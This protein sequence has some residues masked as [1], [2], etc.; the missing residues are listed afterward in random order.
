MV[1][2]Q[3]RFTPGPVD[4][5]DETNAR[6]TYTVSDGNG[7]AV[8]GDISVSV[9]PRIVAQ[10]PYARDDSTFTTVDSPVTI[11]VLR[12]D[13]DPSG[14]RPTLVGI[15]G[16]P[17]GGRAVVTA[18]SQVRYDPPAGRAGAFRCSYEVRNSQGLRAN[19]SIIVSVR[20]PLVTQRGAGHD[21]RFD[22]RR[23]RRRSS[24]ST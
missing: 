17:S 20:E 19:A 6:F 13:G 10:P 15:P 7:H 22:D 8:T 9:L 12:N 4:D 16:C 14:D 5:R 24:R 11:D 3:V 2:D 1:D 23:G 18:D 21:E